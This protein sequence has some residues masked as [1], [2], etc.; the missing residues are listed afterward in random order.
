MRKKVKG[1]IQSVTFLCSKEPL[2]VIRKTDACTFS[3]LLRRRLHRIDGVACGEYNS[4]YYRLDSHYSLSRD[5]W[6]WYREGRWKTY[7]DD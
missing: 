2:P 1:H 4:I 3:F 6:K 7:K 5:F